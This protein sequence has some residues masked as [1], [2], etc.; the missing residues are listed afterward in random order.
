MVRNGD[1]NPI[2]VNRNRVPTIS[3]P[4]GYGGLSRRTYFFT[5]MD[6]ICAERMPSYHIGVHQLNAL[7]SQTFQINQIL[8]IKQLVEITGLSRATIYSLLDPKSKY[9]DAS[10]PQ[11]INLTS[12]RVGWVAHEVNAWITQ[13]I[14]ERSMITN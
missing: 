1:S 2:K 9:Y 11:Q 3:N 14:S 8:N 12:N 7:N 10:F 13:K 6:M 5:V 4:N